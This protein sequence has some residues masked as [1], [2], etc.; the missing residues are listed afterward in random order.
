[1]IDFIGNLKIFFEKA[2]DL[3]NF[4]INTSSFKKFI[5]NYNDNKTDLPE[6]SRIFYDTEVIDFMTEFSQ[7]SI[8][9]EDIYHQHIET[10]GDRP[11]ASEFSTYLKLSTLRAKYNSW[12]EFVHS[13]GGLAEKQI[14]ILNLIKTFFNIRKNSNV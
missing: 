7:K 12:F 8:E 11:S 1:M 3:L 4:N 9:P 13:L 14:A 6:G 10:H 5:D 2:A